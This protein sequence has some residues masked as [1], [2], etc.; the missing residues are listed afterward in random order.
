MR[1][2]QQQEAGPVASSDP[3]GH[4]SLKPRPELP[5]KSF[6]TRAHIWLYCCIGCN[7]QV[8][9]SQPAQTLQALALPLATAQLAS[10]G[11]AC[12]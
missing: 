9:V 7:L 11:P 2:Q 3:Q 10:P 4:E 12:Q 5:A 8:F 1:L 6:A